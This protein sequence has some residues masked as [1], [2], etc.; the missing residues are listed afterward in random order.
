VKLPTL[1]IRAANDKLISLA[2]IRY[3]AQ[4]IPD[5]RL[6]VVNE[7]GHMLP[8]ENATTLWAGEQLCRIIY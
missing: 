7:F 2:R 5:A 1:V 6:E 8:V 4:H 3:Y